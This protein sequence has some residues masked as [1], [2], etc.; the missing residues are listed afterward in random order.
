MQQSCGRARCN[1]A[2]S[3]VLGCRAPFVWDLLH[4]C[5][6]SHVRVHRLACDKT[7]YCTKHSCTT[8]ALLARPPEYWITTL[9]CEAFTSLKSQTPEG[10]MAKAIRF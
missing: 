3:V 2:H 5:A 8:S 10:E 6:K 4:A 7:A 9:S 1:P